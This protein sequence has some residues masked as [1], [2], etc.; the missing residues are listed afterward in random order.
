MN[1]LSDSDDRLE[2]TI[3]TQENI[4]FN[5]LF[6]PRNVFNFIN[7]YK[8]EK[9]VTLL[10]ILSG[11]T[12]TFSRASSNHLG[13]NTSLVGII[14]TSIIIGGIFGWISYYFYA[15]LISWTG[16]WLNGMAN[17]QTILRVIAY[18]S[19]PSVLGLFFLIPQI[20]VYGNEIFKSDGDTMSSGIVGNIIY[21]T[22]VI[23]ELSLGTWSFVLCVIGIAVVQKFSIG[24]A[25]FNLVLP[26]IIFLTVIFVL[27]LVFKV[28]T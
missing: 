11:I 1:E 7:K 21:Y 23:L 24:K 12:R 2:E 28:L 5:L 18:S 13:D 8:Y 16:N 22:S 26:A 14:G 10:L 27:V 19:F 15:S 9:H 4:F 17:S 6:S 3:I 25:F 20:A